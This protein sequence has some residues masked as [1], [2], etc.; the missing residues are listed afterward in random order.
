MTGPVSSVQVL[1]H[2]SGADALPVEK[3]IS[4]DKHHQHGGTVYADWRIV[5]VAI[6]MWL[7]CLSTFWVFHRVSGQVGPSAQRSDTASLTSPE[8]DVGI[9]SFV[10]LALLCIVATVIFMT[11]RARAAHVRTSLPSTIAVCSCTVLLAAV[12]TWNVAYRQAHDPASLLAHNA[13]TIY[14][15][16]RV[17]TPAIVSTMR[18]AR[19]QSDAQLI[20]ISDGG[21]DQLS[22]IKVR[23]FA[24]E[25]VCS[26]LVEGTV[27]S[28]AGTIQDAKYG[29]IPVWLV[30]DEDRGIE[31]LKPPDMMHRAIH[32]MRES[33]FRTCVRLDDQGRVLVPGLTMGLVGSQHISDTA[34]VDP[35]YAKALDTRF[36]RAGIMHL[37]AVSGGHFLLI[38]Q[39]VRKVCATFRMHHKAV[40]V[41]IMLACAG[42]AVA[43]YPSDSVL[44]ALIMMVFHA[45]AVWFGRPPKPLN[46]L[47]WTIAIIL[48]SD[49]SKSQSFGFALSCA[50]V[51]G[52]VI[53]APSFARWFALQLPDALSNALAVSLSAMLFTLPLQVL[54]KA[55]IPV[56]SLYANLLVN[57]VVDIATMSGLIAM[58]IAPMSTT[59]AFPFAWI[60]SCGTAVMDWCAALLGGNNS[61]M[62]WPSG[63]VGFALVIAIELLIAA[64]CWFGTRHMRSSFHR[65]YG[66]RYGAVF[67]RSLGQSIRQWFVDTI[68]ML[69]KIPSDRYQENCP[70]I[71]R[72]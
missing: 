71:R 56:L 4:S 60:S 51:F 7:S 68:A 63:I 28:G 50:A 18:E 30:L 31:M 47:G 3:E 22:S 37:M 44:R 34:P 26:Q 9:V 20:T 5:I 48:I 6:C 33:L 64:A 23:V 43:M 67:H 32:A 57:P 12:A 10:W 2:M 52:I 16:W 45:S 40:A 69:D 54:M 36:I 49:P 55:Q 1:R 17:I 70:T 15:Q 46:A 41:L 53:C 24:H 11:I 21:I 35:A 72:D 42:L 8:T 65:R 25:S 58:C 59:L 19:C 29:A 39:L 62:P 27:M 38:A 14:A 61:V 13:T 66:I